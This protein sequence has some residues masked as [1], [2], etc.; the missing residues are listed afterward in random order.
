V[1]IL[2]EPKWLKKGKDT[3]GIVEKIR[4]KQE[5]G[6]RGHGILCVIFLSYMKKGILNNSYFYYARNPDDR[7][8]KIAPK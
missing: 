7:P 1:R 3:I 6:N 4:N 2:T 8:I 5:P